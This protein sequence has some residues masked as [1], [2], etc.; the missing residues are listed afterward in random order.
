MCHFYSNSGAIGP[1]LRHASCA[2]RRFGLDERVVI[3]GARVRR[4]ASSENST[5]MSHSSGMRK[6]AHL[7]AVL[8]CFARRWHGAYIDGFAGPQEPE[9]PEIWTAK[10]VLELEPKRLGQFFLC[11]LNRKSYRALLALI[12]RHQDDPRRKINTYNTDFNKAV[13]EI[14]ASG[15]IRETTA[16]FCLLDQRTFQLEQLNLHSS[17]CFR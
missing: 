2:M 7:V 11:E 15:N 12:G 6:L 4:A 1:H 13:H 14:L 8:A 10:L 3:S 9:M 16:T 5:G 17:F